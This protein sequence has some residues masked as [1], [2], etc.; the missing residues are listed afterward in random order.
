MSALPS[1][2]R[3]LAAVMNWHRWSWTC[4]E[5]RWLNRN[6]G[7]CWQIYLDIN[8]N[9]ADYISMAYFPQR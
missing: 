1:V 7:N 5:I 2:N 4:F 9:D 3:R 6:N 8:H